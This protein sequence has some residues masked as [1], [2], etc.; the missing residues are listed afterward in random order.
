MQAMARWLGEPKKVALLLAAGLAAVVMLGVAASAATA[1]TFSNN[2]GITFNDGGN[3]DPSTLEPLAPGTATPYPSSIEVSGLGSSVTDVNVTVSGLSHSFPDD[4]GLLLVSPAGQSVILMADNGGTVLSSSVNFTFDDAAPGGLPDSEE[5]SS[6]TYKPSRGTN[7]S[8]GCNN[9]ASFPGTAPAGPYG[10]SLSVFNGTNPNGTWQLYVIDDTSGDTGSITSWSLDISTTT[11][12]E[13]RLSPGDDVYVERAC[14]PDGDETVF[15]RGGADR[16]RLNLCGDTENEPAETTDS[17]IDVANGQAGNDRIRVDDGDIYDTARG[18]VGT[19]RCTGDLDLGD[20]VDDVDE[21]PI[22]P[23]G[24]T[25]T[26]EDTGDTLLCEQK[27]YV[28]GEFYN[29]S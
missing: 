5:P 12:E 2:S 8:Q 23:G 3:C 26:E 24:G 7:P 17:D 20:G 10:S 6:G 13:V 29:Q 14:P 22:G 19:D 9:P 4:I 15:A 28:I 11:V 18:G 25:G 27:T 21:P 16:L 1:A